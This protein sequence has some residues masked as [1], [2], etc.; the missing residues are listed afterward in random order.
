MNIKHCNSNTV[1]EPLTFPKSTALFL[2]ICNMS[3]C[4]IKLGIIL[5][6]VKIS[7]LFLI[8]LLINSINIVMVML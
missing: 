3:K 4:L 1:L 6:F 7:L 5:E 8:Y 2:K